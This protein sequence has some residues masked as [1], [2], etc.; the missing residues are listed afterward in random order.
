MSCTVERD[1][2]LDAP[3]DEVWDELPSLFEDDAEHDLVVEE[4]VPGQRLAFL[5]S[6]TTTDEPASY[7]EIELE[8]QG[9]GTL[10]HIKETRLDGDLLTRT[11]FNAS[12]LV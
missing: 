2:E 3:P 9:T 10:L 12:A 4:Q 11:A 7:V 8:P 6:D 1:Y 5:W